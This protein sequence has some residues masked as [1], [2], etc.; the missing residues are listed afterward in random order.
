MLKTNYIYASAKI[1][2]LEKLILNATDI[3][4][5]V[6]APDLDSAFKV[7]H[8][9]DYRDNLLDVE[10]VNYRQ[11][12]STDF[13]QFYLFLQKQNLQPE[14]YELM[15]IERDFVNI[16]L[17]F[18]SKLFGVDVTPH[19][20]E[21]VLFPL[22]ELKNFILNLPGQPASHVGKTAKGRAGKT[23]KEKLKKIIF[24]ASQKF[25]EKTKPDLVDTVL[26][27]K[28]FS[29]KLELAKK[30][31]SQFIT[32]Y[33]E[34]EIDSANLLIFI[35]GKR[36]NLTKERLAEKLIQGGRADINRLTLQYAEELR[37]IKP[38]VSANFNQRVVQIFDEFCEKNNLFEVEK[39]IDNFKIK[40][41]RQAKMIPYGQD[42]IFAYYLAKQNAITNIRIILTSKLSK[43]P[44]EA[45]KQTLRE[46][47]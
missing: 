44:G 40:F 5:M 46:V 45:I 1:R 25:D 32:N 20:K 6:D 22:A 42:V 23:I 30:I 19:L 9:T 39:A 3:E 41:A 2:A 7:L 18:K 36:L 12:L 35:R 4:R 34:K 8:D 10:P 17:L 33:L 16:K 28:Y 14:L 27:Q 24:E 38:F 37:S 29:L 11:A 15:L 31:K 13:Q 26:T 47:F 43:L 21:N